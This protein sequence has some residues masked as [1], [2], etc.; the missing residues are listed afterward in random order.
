VN[1]LCKWFAIACTAS[2]AYVVDGDTISIDRQH[3][4]LAGIDA[5]ELSEPHGEA[6]RQHLVRLI[7]GDPVRCVFD[8]WSY[9][10]RVGV[11]S[12]VTPKPLGEGGT[13]E[14]NAAMVRDGFAL[15]CAHYSQGRYRRLEP[16]GIRL[17]LIQKP[18][19]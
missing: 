19:C 16:V 2:Q 4:R 18:Y 7:G 6:A 12:L 15:D 1:L 17:K 13:F 9:N 11:C 3:I 10:R 8:G 5:E 14:L